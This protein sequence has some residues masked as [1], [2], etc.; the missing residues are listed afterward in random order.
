MPPV[1]LPAIH[2]SGR[3]WTPLSTAPTDT[4]TLHIITLNTWFSPFGRTQRLRAQL[5]ALGSRS[6]DVI[7]LQ[8]VTDDLL[9]LLLDCPWVRADYAMVSEPHR[10]LA[11]HGYGLA[12]LAKRTL[13]KAFSWT[14][15]KSDMGRSLL[16]AEL[17][18]GVHV[19][20]VH[21]E[22][23][24]G[25]GS[26][27]AQQL[28]ACTQ[29]LSPAK[30]ALLL[31]DFNF[32]PTESDAP[33]L[34]PWLDLWSVAHPHDPGFTADGVINSMRRRPGIPP[35]QRRIDRAVLSDATGGWKL[36]CIALFG[37]KPVG[38]HLWMSDHFG[39]ELTM[40]RTLER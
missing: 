16:V 28:T 29:L 18:E 33:P 38:P 30:T 20:T 2:W 37:T 32:D 21:L 14:P 9:E 24:R 1:A 25:Y 36:D 7:C 19:G 8:E 26:A 31:G 15:L 6:P 22:S 35:M 12:L 17:G 11:S 3:Q 27:R 40:Q 23:M 4:D 39:L 5:A 13:V 10:P 34:G